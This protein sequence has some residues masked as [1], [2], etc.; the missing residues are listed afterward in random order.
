M[1][2]KY[3]SHHTI[4]E[5]EKFKTQMLIWANRFNI[6]AL[7]DNHQYHSPHQNIDCILAVGAIDACLP[8]DNHLQELS[9]WLEGK[10]QRV[11]R[12]SFL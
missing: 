2:S 1:L 5:P 11:F 10:T 9:Q 6:C 8:T 12:A 7:L 4:P 3:S